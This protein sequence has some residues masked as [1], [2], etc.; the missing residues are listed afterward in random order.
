RDRSERLRAQVRSLVAPPQSIQGMSE[1]MR[2]MLRMAQDEVADM[3]ASRRPQAERRIAEADQRAAEELA[4]ARAQADEIRAEATRL[5]E[6]SAH[7]HARRP[8]PARA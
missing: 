6:Q 8:P 1:R 2:S 3:Q 7:A 4:T 5:A